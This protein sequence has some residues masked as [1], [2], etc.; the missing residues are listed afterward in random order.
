MSLALIH[1]IFSRLENEI[2]A[3]SADPERIAS[4]FTPGSD[5]RNAFW[6]NVVDDAEGFMNEEKTDMNDL[7]ETA[8]LEEARSPVTAETKVDNKSARDR[9]I[10]NRA[11]ADKMAQ[12]AKPTVERFFR[13]LKNARAFDRGGANTVP[14]KFGYMLKV[15]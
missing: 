12:L 5:E 8:K 3:C 11:L 4:I 7:I 2:G 6:Q 1:G 14:F 13:C 15:V 9:A 10:R